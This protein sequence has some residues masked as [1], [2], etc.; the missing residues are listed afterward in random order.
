[1]SRFSCSF[2]SRNSDLR[3]RKLLEDDDD[4]DDDDD[5]DDDDGDGDPSRRW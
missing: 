1:V 2:I 4:V 5:N 3:S